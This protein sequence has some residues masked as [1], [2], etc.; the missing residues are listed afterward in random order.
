MNSNN[1]LFTNKFIENLDSSDIS[2]NQ[3]EQFRRYH[4]ER[5]AN[6]NRKKYLDVS[7]IPPKVSKND[8]DIV[9]STDVYSNLTKFSANEVSHRDTGAFSS[10]QVLKFEKRTIVSLDTRDRDINKYP[11]QNDFKAFLGK[12]FFNVKS[13]ELVSTEFPN[14][15]QVIKDTPIELQNNLITWQNEE[16]ISYNIYSNLDMFTTEI[17]YVDIFLPGHGYTVGSSIIARL[18]NNTDSNLVDGERELSVINDG[19]FRFPY[20]GGVVGGSKTDLDLGIPTYTVVIK[21]GNYTASTLAEEMTIQMGLVRRSKGSN[22]PEEDRDFHNFTVSVNLDTDVI[23]IDSV[24]A[25]QLQIDAISTTFNSTTITVNQPEHGFKTG[26]RVK[27]VGIK[28]FA[29]IPATVLNGDYNVNVSSSHVFTYEV[30]VKANE[31]V[32]GGGNTILSCRDAPFRLLFDTENTKIQFNTGFPDEDSSEP[33]NSIDPITTKALKISSVDIIS[34][35][36]VRFTTIEQ[37][38]L[39]AVQI[40]NISSITKYVPAD[41]FSQPVITTIA[42]HGIYIPTRI[43]VRGSNSTPNIDGT[44]IGTP[45]GANTILVTTLLISNTGTTGQVVY[46]QDKIK[47]FGLQTVPNILINPVYFV[48]N[49]PST[50]QFD[51]TFKATQI[52]IESI[53]N[54]I[55]GTSH[56][57]VNHPNHGFNQLSKITQ[58]PSNFANIT[59]FV[60]HTLV[61]SRTTGIT[62]TVDL[63]EPDIFTVALPRHGLSTS[64]T[65]A[66]QDIIS[67]YSALNIESITVD[68]IDENTL[69]FT[70]SL[71]PLIFTPGLNIYNA[72]IIS[73]D[74]VTLS[75]TNSIPSIDGAYK[76]HNRL[77]IS[78]IKTPNY[79][80]ITTQTPNTFSSGNSIT[81]IGSNSIPSID[82]TYTIT[83]IISPGSVFEIFIEFTVTIAGSTGVINNNTTLEVNNVQSTTISNVIYTEIETSTTNNWEQ[84]DIIKI[85]DTGS[86]ALP[87]PTQNINGTYIIENVVSSTIFKIIYEAP[88]E[89]VITNTGIA[90]N[91][92][93]MEIDLDTITLVTQGTFPAGIIGR[94][95]NVLHY[96]IVGE[97]NG[98]DNIAGISLNVLN[99]YKRSIAQIID[100]DNYMMRVIDEY[101]DHTITAGGNNVHVSS[102]L[103][104]LRSI[105]VNTEDGTTTGVLFRSI[106]LEGENYVYLVC[107]SEG[108]ELNTVFNSGNI[109]NAF[110]KII[111]SE[112]PG[113]LMFNSYISEA[114]V[115]DNPISK[116]DTMRIR[117]ITPGGYPFNFKGINYSFTIRITELVNQLDESFVSSRTGTNEFKNLITKGHLSLGGKGL[118]DETGKNTSLTNTSGPGFAIR[119][120]GG[121]G[122]NN[123]L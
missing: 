78:S 94:N 41:E 59:T 14:T 82:G 27:M 122:Y 12:T 32:D 16:D 68:I 10:T 109:P 112:S 21:P 23:T 93:K 108:V 29:G 49:I 75:N 101:A 47:I 76:I 91:T 77:L 4:E 7:K 70:R 17:D 117:V 48:E 97:Y 86:T 13:I 61:G 46:G 51:I 69:S 79:I 36:K 71:N 31:T 84:G 100:V 99:G 64:D 95:L 28:T 8:K 20:Q 118:G 114:K 87:S 105:Q 30:I 33:I 89:A 85:S 107:E 55:I 119:S 3:K 66:I 90:I 62:I 18:F 73:G 54:S 43:T 63:V 24:V 72:T 96:R 80:E 5:I 34:T 83:S 60:P 44:Y 123:A 39:Q 25:T 11:D 50:T 38:G 58:L 106:S 111:L 35:D 81:I 65:I 42:S 26:D 113:N 57:Y 1:R 104:G 120:S 37:H 19:T 53:P 115:F 74:I 103:H 45:I 98:A 121:R 22:I 9:N 52:D 2:S 92:T 15:D 6:Q 88:L 102:Y 116:I 67:P 40:K 56:I 110:A